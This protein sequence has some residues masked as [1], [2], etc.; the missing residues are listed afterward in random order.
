MKLGNVVAGF[1][2]RPSVPSAG[3]ATG[4]RALPG[5]P[6]FHEDTRIGNGSMG[7]H[8]GPIGPIRSSSIVRDP[9]HCA[10]ATGGIG[11]EVTR[12]SCRFRIPRSA[13]TSSQ[14]RSSPYFTRLAMLLWLQG[15]SALRLS[16][17][18][19]SIPL[20]SSRTNVDRRCAFHL[21]QPGLDL[22]GAKMSTMRA[23][24]RTSFAPN[25]DARAR[26]GASQRW[27]HRTHRAFAPS[28][29]HW[30]DRRKTGTRW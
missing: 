22:V 29:T 7:G 1:R 13:L 12:H 17:L 23:W 10:E 4:Q 19:R 26:S 20:L 8:V 2:L 15:F 9:V 5:H 6:R 14:S 3:G 11:T 21:A 24:V 25:R 27:P 28:R 16:S 18:P 30:S